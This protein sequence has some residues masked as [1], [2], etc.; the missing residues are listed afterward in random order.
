MA[1]H[2]YRLGCEGK[3]FVSKWLLAKFVGKIAA[4]HL[5]F[6]TSRLYLCH[7][8]QSIHSREGWDQCVKVRV[9]NYG[10]KLLKGFFQSIPLYFVVPLGGYLV[11]VQSYSVIHWCQPVGVGCTHWRV[12][13]RWNLEWPW[14]NRTYL[15]AWVESCASCV[16]N[17]CMEILEEK[18]IAF[19]R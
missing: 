19:Y 5:A 1:K 18:I 8:Y 12:T 16:G 6:P 14:C 13:I 11:V 9:T 3:R 2:L 7:F 4:W 17:N 15:F 10:M